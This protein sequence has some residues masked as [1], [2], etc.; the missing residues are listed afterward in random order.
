MCAIPSA[1]DRV[2]SACGSD[3]LWHVVVEP[4]DC[5]SLVVGLWPAGGQSNSAFY[6]GLGVSYGVA[7]IVCVCGGGGCWHV[8][9]QPRRE[10]DSVLGVSR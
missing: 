1:S 8:V 6:Q 3:P 2:Q 4:K 7:E 5:Q 10:P 9:V